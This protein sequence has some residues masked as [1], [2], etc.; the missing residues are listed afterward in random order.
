MSISDLWA[1]SLEEHPAEKKP[2][3]GHLTG[4][5]PAKATRK[6]LAEGHPVGKEP[7]ERHPVE[8]E[9]EVVGKKPVEEYLARTEGRLVKQSVTPP[10]MPKGRSLRQGESSMGEIILS[11]CSLFGKK[12]RL[13]SPLS[14]AIGAARAQV[15]RKR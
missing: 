10:G 1:G 8:K 2:T 13:P 12:K 6:E 4:K 7:A 3:E 9:P 5:E 14:I 11:A 15:E